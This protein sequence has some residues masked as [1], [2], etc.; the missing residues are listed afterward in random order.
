MRTKKT[1]SMPKSLIDKVREALESQDINKI[2][3]IPT[4]ILEAYRDQHASEKHK[5]E[6]GHIITLRQVGFYS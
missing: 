6:L 2:A 1:Y 5:H 4:K 3:C